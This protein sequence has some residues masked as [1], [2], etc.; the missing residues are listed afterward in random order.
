MDGPTRWWRWT[1]K[2]T[3]RTVCSR[4]V[5]ADICLTPAAHSMYF[6]AL[7]WWADL[8][9]LPLTWPSWTCWI[10]RWI[11]SS[12]PL[13]SFHNCCRCFCAWEMLPSF[14]EWSNKCL[15]KLLQEHPPLVL[16]TRHPARVEV[17]PYHIGIVG[18]NINDLVEDDQGPTSSHPSTALRSN[19]F[20]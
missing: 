18:G 13:K 10:F 8:T 4:T 7:L 19:H 11:I 1:S 17:S 3:C 2:S 16:L 12:S 14:N 9:P 6:T 20:V 5:L 15:S